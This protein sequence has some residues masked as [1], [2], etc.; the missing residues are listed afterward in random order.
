MAG[1]NVIEDQKWYSSDSDCLRKWYGSAHL[2][3]K[4]YRKGE[5][6]ESNGEEVEQPALID[7]G[8][9]TDLNKRATWM[10]QNVTQLLS[11]TSR[12]AYRPEVSALYYGTL[13]DNIARWDRER[14]NKLVSTETVTSET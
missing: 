2:P 13:Y 6:T 5:I 10:D 3:M 14:K 12:D 9:T 8:A 7:T 11:S 4:W 1:K